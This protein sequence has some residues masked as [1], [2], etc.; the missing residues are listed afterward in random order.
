MTHDTQSLNESVSLISIPSCHTESVSGEVQQTTES[1]SIHQKIFRIMSYTNKKSSVRNC[2]DV[3]FT[4]TYQQKLS[5]LPSIV[6]SMEKMWGGI[7]FTY[8]QYTS[9]V[10]T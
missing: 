10:Q 3:Q 9:I 5:L 4:A 6:G 2:V 7:K 8:T 1:I